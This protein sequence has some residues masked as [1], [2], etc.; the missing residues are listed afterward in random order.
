MQQANLELLQRGNVGAGA[1]QPQPPGT[2]NAADV[3]GNIAAFY[4]L[5]TSG[6]AAAAAAASAPAASGSAAGNGGGIGG[7]SG[8]NGGV[9]GIGGNSG[10]VGVSAF[11]NNGPSAF[12]PIQPLHSAGIAA[13]NAYSMQRQ[14]SDA[15]NVSDC[16]LSIIKYFILWP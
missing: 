5:P 6:P 7:I 11:S 8:N 12:S 3:F 1:P 13:A 4:G 10:G 16:V 14:Q 9:G 2:P 15:W